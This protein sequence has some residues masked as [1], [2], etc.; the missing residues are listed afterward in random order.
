MIGF[1]WDAGCGLIARLR[2]RC[3]LDGSNSETKCLHRLLLAA[4]ER[5]D[6]LEP[7]KQRRNEV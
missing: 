3:R 7:F 4:I 2:Q 5:A 6:F 1:N